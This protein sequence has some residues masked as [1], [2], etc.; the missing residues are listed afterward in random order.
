MLGFQ[1]VQADRVYAALDLPQKWEVGAWN[2][3][4]TS[5]CFS[6]KLGVGAWTTSFASNKL[7]S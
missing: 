5:V 6:Y 3:V 1:K 4:I 7:A 2:Y